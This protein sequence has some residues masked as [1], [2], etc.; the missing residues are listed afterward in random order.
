MLDA[1]D[2]E[3]APADPI[4]HGGRLTTVDR[5]HLASLEAVLAG[6]TVIDG[7][8]LGVTLTVDCGAVE[9]RVS[10][11]TAELSLPF[12]RAELHPA[13]VRRVVA[14]A[15]TRYRFALGGRQSKWLKGVS[16][17]QRSQLFQGGR[18]Q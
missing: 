12:D 8:G 14:D 2:A 11:P 9:V 6:D 4:G 17:V 3:V 15:V 1:L 16:L 18:Q 13:Y 5:G 10:G 7:A